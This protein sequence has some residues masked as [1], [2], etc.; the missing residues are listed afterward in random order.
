MTD[1]VVMA[2]VIEGINR[3]SPLDWSVSAFMVLAGL[4]FIRVGYRF[5]A[6][7]PTVKTVIGTFRLCRA[8]IIGLRRGGWGYRPGARGHDHHAL[9]LAVIPRQRTPAQ[10]I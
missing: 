1:P 6:E 7:G 8:G 9:G 4:F 10:K 3:N 5:F 2:T